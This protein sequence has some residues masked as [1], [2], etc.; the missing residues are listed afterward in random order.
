MKK[1]ILLIVLFCSVFVQSQTVTIRF[2]VLEDGHK[3]QYKESF[4]KIYEDDSMLL[5]IGD[6]YDDIIVYDSR[7]RN[8][9][10]LEIFDFKVYSEKGMK[11]RLLI[12][13]DYNIMKIIFED[14]SSLML[15]NE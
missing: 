14:K 7:M 2:N 15:Y 8:E 1:F 13:P 9:S 12:E 6:Y 11:F 10:G 3:K 4:L 5:K